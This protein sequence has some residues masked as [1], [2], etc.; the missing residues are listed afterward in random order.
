M[1]RLY[2]YRVLL[3]SSAFWQSHKEAGIFL[4]LGWPALT[5]GERCTIIAPPHVCLWH[6]NNARRTPF[7]RNTNLRKYLGLITKPWWTNT[8]VTRS[9]CPQSVD[10]LARSCESVQLYQSNASVVLLCLLADGWHLETAP[11]HPPFT[12][13][14]WFVVSFILSPLPSIS[15]VL[16]RFSHPRWV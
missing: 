2:A 3:P 6:S 8:G 15:A 7:N 1:W 5:S 14:V 16:L 11:C 10:T 9:L 12:F 4:F 13:G